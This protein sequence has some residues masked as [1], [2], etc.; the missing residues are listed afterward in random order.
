MV[1]INWSA[2]VGAYEG[3]WVGVVAGADGLRECVSPR[4][5]YLH[6]FV[7]FFGFL[8]ILCASG[9]F[10]LCVHYRK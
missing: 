9:Y 1:C 4:Q 3:G 5:D 8:R 10:I 7:D 2:C 6:H